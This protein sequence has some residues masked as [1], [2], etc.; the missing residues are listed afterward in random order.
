[1]PKLR[2]RTVF[3]RYR[4]LIVFLMH[5]SMDFLMDFLIEFCSKRIQILMFLIDCYVRACLCFA[6]FLS[7]V[8]CCLAC[9]IYCSV[10]LSADR[11]ERRD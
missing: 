4:F 2:K 3:G 11:N 6:S 10:D 7:K 8:M 5:F 9:F 1:M